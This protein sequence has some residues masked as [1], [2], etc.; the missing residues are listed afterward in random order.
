[1]QQ[2]KVAI[3][4]AGLTGLSLAYFLKKE[5][6][7]CKIFE[8][9]NTC[10]GV[11]KSF[12]EGGYTFES[13]PNT[14]VLGNIEIEQ[15]LSELQDTCKLE[16]AAETAKKR[17]ILKNNSWEA[18][19]SGLLS[20]INTPLFSTYDK[21]R[22][23]GEP[24][25]N[26]GKN[27]NETVR[28]MVERRL[29]KSF[30]DYAVAPFINGVYAGNTD[31]LI[32]RFA[33]SKLYALE[34]EYG[35]F[36]KGSISKQRKNKKL[37]IP[38]PSKKVFSTEGGLQSFIKALESK[39]LN[40]IEYS[41][42][43]I[44][45]SK[46]QDKY[47]IMWNQNNTEQTEIFSH[48]ISTINA[49]EIP[50]ILPWIDSSDKE[51]F[52]SVSYAPVVQACVGFKNWDG[53]NINAFGGLIPPKEKRDL[54]GILFTSSMFPNRAPKNGAMLSIFMGGALRKDIIEKNEEELKEIIKRETSELLQIQNWNPEIIKIF[55][56]PY[57]ITQYTIHMEKVNHTILKIEDSNPNLII[58]GS[59]CNGIGMADRVKQSYNIALKIL[60]QE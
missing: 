18:L 56:H 15:L 39:I 41:C 45:I 54:L 7:T 52:N 17:L 11:I 12:T 31:E 36:I 60:H 22:I 59:I 55:K 58:G 50:N 46:F 6:I 47:S 10:G 5:G 53:I 16:I 4:G 33:L 13:G 40:Q 24:F 29:G 48:V 30:H 1:M 19:P 51:I 9:S 23:L 25:R 20:A 57:A 42:N 43:Q 27:P 37:G 28:E 38:S 3:I 32:T 21:F 8:K 49:H 14:G 35:S 34:Q 2:K 26:K 44:L